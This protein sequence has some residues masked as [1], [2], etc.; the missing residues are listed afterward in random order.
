MAPNWLFNQEI[1]V[2]AHNILI[3]LALSSDFSLIAY[4]L[5]GASFLDRISLTITI[6]PKVDW[7]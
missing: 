4:L 3:W 6:S 7:P 1:M 5:L 2:Q